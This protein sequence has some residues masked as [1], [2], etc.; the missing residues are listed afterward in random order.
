MVIDRKGE[1]IYIDE[2][3]FNTASGDIRQRNVQRQYQQIYRTYP[4]ADQ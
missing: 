1:E 2:R 4:K 3:I